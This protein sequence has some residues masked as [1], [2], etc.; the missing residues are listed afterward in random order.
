MANFE[1]CRVC[2][3][4][5]V[6][7]YN[8]HS[9]NLQNIYENL[10]GILITIPEKYPNYLC[11]YCQ[12]L[13]VKSNNFKET[14]IRTHEL[15]QSMVAKLAQKQLPN[16]FLTVSPV[17]TISISSNTSTNIKGTL[18]KKIRRRN[19]ASNSKLKELNQTQSQLPKSPKTVS[20]NLD[21]KNAEMESIDSETM[22]A[23]D[24][25]A[26][27]TEQE[28]HLNKKDV[29]EISLSKVQQ[30]QE[31]LAR[32]NSANF[33][34]ALY[35]CDLCYVGFMSDFSFKNHMVT[36]DLSSGS[37]ICDICKTRYQTEK[38]LKSHCKTVH[39]MKYI[40]K[41]CDYVSRTCQQAKKHIK[42]HQ[43]H[44]YVC[45]TCGES[46]SSSK[47]LLSHVRS[48]H[49]SKY[50]CECCGDSFVS[51]KGLA[52]HRKKAHNLNELLHPMRREL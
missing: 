28:T 32:K 50:C 31:F 8:M 27:I 24:L 26:E 16:F 20:D 38:T 49:P 52:L 48:E 30:L 11:V 6:K 40:C 14:C 35:K 41:K 23:M 2:L 29:E 34:N 1:A 43:G 5:N 3:A 25:D 37:H 33:Q 18:A 47:T 17:K 39:E 4:T 46:C 36:H 44:S 51:Q 10:T 15:L 21:D 19:S 45:K 13:L 7:L 12:S 42:W 22:E 9:Y